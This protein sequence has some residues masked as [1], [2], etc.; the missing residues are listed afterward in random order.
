[1]EMSQAKKK[2]IKPK[3]LPLT[4]RNAYQRFEDVI[5]CKWSSAVVAAVAQ[6]VK[7]PG[8][9]ER[10]IPG[11]STKVLTERLRKLGAFGLLTRTEYDGLPARVEYELTVAGHRLAGILVQVKAMNEEHHLPPT[12]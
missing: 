11:I 6:G 3:Y 12:E 1:M 2:D 8:E 5:G 4:E 7:R 10:F 9:L